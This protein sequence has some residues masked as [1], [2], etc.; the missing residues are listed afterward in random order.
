VTAGELGLPLR[1]QD[2]GGGVETLIVVVHEVALGEHLAAAHEPAAVDPEA[3]PHRHL[4]A[5]T[6]ERHDP[7]GMTADGL[8][9]DD[10]GATGGVK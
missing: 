6:K 9:A 4:A 7:G 5:A 3:E 8:A 2:R 1:R 10:P